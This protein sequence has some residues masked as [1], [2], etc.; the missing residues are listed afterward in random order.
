QFLS[1]VRYRQGVHHACPCERPLR[2]GGKRQGELGGGAPARPFLLGE[3][4]A[5]I[6]ME[7]EVAVERWPIAGTFTIARGSK[8][9]ATVVV[10]TIRDGA[11]VRRWECVPYAHYGETIE[12]VAADIRR[13]AGVTLGGLNRIE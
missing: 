5:T 3:P 6:A 9:E 13:H 7:V 11:I 1:H 2:L 12:G 4:G 10:A 8:R